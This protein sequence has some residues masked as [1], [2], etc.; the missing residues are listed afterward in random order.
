VGRVWSSAVLA[1]GVVFVV[2]LFFLFGGG[3]VVHHQSVAI[4]ATAVS[5]SPEAALF[6]DRFVLDRTGN[7]EVKVQAPVS[8]SWLYLDGA[9]INEETGEVDEFDLEVSYYAGVDS[10]GSWSEGGQGARTYV[11]GVPPGRYVLRLAPQWEAGHPVSGYDLEVRS[12]VPRF[13][14]VALA[15]LALRFW[16]I[17]LSWRSFR[18][19]MERWSESDHAWV[20]VSS[21]GEGEE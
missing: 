13:Y 12:R 7:L 1:I 16:P 8:N 19:E 5:G 9:L 21:S 15:A 14:Q 17:V 2:Y 11:A 18:F 10:D 20:S 6:T 3:R 4:P